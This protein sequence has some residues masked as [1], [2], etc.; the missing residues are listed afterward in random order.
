RSYKREN[1]RLTEKQVDYGIIDPASY[2]G[3]QLGKD[4]RLKLAIRRDTTPDRSKIKYWVVIN[5]TEVALDVSEKKLTSNDLRSRQKNKL[6]CGFFTQASLGV[7]GS[8]EV[9][10]VRLVY[11][12]GLGGRKR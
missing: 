1:N 5:G 7:K 10:R 11:D 9:E 4:E 8:V 12:S 2:G 6:R 3:I